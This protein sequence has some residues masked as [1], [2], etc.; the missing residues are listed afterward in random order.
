MQFKSAPLR[1][2]ATIAAG[3]PIRDAVRD[4]PGAETAVV[5]IK[6]VDAGAGIDWSTVV[7]TELTGRKQ[8]DW[9]QT[10][11]VL[12][13]ARGQ[14]NVAVWVES[15]P[16]KTVCSPHFFLIRIRDSN[17][18]LPE[19]IAWQM[20]LPKAQQYFAQ[21]ATGS[22]ITSIRRQ[23]LENLEVAIP[24]LDR[25]LLLVR[26]ARL[27]QREKEVLGGLIDNRRKELDVL[28]R[29]LLTESE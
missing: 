25:Q 28:A 14:R 24:S 13:A 5:Q 19:F 17:A 20:N 3:H 1:S 26:F 11:D 4:I 27:V 18:V 15:P 2:I 6:N 22:F 29:E 7:H 9:L 10:G 21:S 23:V 12:F 16:P 8:P